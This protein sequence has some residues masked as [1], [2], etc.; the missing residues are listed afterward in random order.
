MLDVETCNTRGAR[1]DGARRCEPR[2]AERPRSQPNA[3]VTSTG[4]MPQHVVPWARSR[5]SDAA[6]RG[7]DG[8]GVGVKF[9]G[10]LT[11][12]SRG[13]ERGNGGGGSRRRCRRRAAGNA[14]AARCLSRVSPPAG[15]REIHS[16][17]Q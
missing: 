3:N 2:R 16:H 4:V 14:Y 8:G 13:R 5:A 1:G 6:R 9:R 17:A 7:S 11:S 12:V 15:A 10:L